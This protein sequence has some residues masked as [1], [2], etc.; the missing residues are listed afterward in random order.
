[1]V[2]QKLSASLGADVAK[3]LADKRTAERFL[4]HLKERP[5]GE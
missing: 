1:M 3:L 5:E 2:D 4:K